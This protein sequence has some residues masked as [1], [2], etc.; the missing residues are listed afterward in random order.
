MRL[1]LRL[2]ALA[3]LACLAA[4]PAR[5]DPYPSKPVRIIVTVSPGGIT[6]IVARMAGEYLTAKTGQAVVVENRTGAGGN[7]GTEAVAKA[8]P[9][10]LTL[11]VMA[12][13]QI[14]I[15][16]HTTRSPI[17]D[18]LTELVPVAPL[19][20]VPQ[21]LVINPKIPTKTLSEFIAYA[22]E[23]RGKLNSVSLGPGSTPHL[24]AA[25]FAR[26]AGIEMVAVQYRGTAPGIADVVSGTMDMISVGGAPVLALIRSGELRALAAA[27]TRR[28]PYLPDVPT[29]A[30]A[31]LP[32]YEMSTWF[33]LFAPAGTPAPIVAQLNAWMREM[34]ADPAVQKRFADLAIEPMSMGAADFATFV[35][36]ES[37][38][39]K[40][41]V[42]ETRSKAQ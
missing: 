32:G 24:A 27:S 37:A 38:R 16:P 39:W 18:P 29:S 15:N 33:A 22:K 21:L 23:R 26:L 9:D 4:L 25:Q 7:I 41:I 36:A 20:D 10:G 3:A 13:S 40:Q 1:I 2:A 14:A 34:T 12:T 42:D 28:L 6:D 5:A 19:G 8:A 30:E 31:G 35:K 17:F 11:G